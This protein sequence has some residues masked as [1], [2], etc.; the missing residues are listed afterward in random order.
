MQTAYLVLTLTLFA[1]MAGICVLLHRRLRGSGVKNPPLGRLIILVFT[2]G[3]GLHV[4]LSI[5]LFFNDTSSRNIAIDRSTLIGSTLEIVTSAL[6][7][8][9]ILVAPIVILVIGAVS[10]IK[11]G[12]SSYHRVVYLACAGYTFFILAFFILLASTCSTPPH[13]IP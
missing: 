9:V 1:I 6:W 10:F 8:Y 2:Y 4:F 7:I 12:D 13:G 11:K 5:L 3:S